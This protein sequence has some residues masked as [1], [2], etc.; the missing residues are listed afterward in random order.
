MTIDQAMRKQLD[1]KLELGQLSMRGYDRCLRLAWTL[2][3][4]AGEANPS[5]GHISQALYLRGQDNP[6]E[7][8]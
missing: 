4:L 8:A 6:M 3:D 2:A 1:R 7:V 5:E